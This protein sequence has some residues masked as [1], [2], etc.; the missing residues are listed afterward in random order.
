MRKDPD[1][2]LA[3]AL[4]PSL[5]VDLHLPEPV[6]EV[7]PEETV[8][9]LDAIAV[10]SDVDT[11]ASTMSITI[12]TSVAS[13]DADTDPEAVQPTVVVPLPE[14][15]E[16]PEHPAAAPSRASRRTKAEK[17][18][19]PG[20]KPAPEGSWPEFV[21]AASLH[22]VNLGDSARVRARKALDARIARSFDDRPRFVP[23]LSRKGG[24]GKT[25]VTVLLGMALAEVR[26]DR[27]LAIDANPDRGTLAD[28][29][30]RQTRSTV[31]DIVLHAPEL[32]G[33]D[34]LAGHVS[35]DATGLDVAASD[36]DPLLAEAFDDGGYN[37]VADVV[38]PHY[39]VVVTDSGTGVVHSVMRASLQ[40]A[41]AVVV[42]SGGSIDEARL[43]SETL[44]WLEA[45]NYGHLVAD[46]V[47]ALN[48]STQGTDLDKLHDIEDHFR[49][50]VRAVVRIPYDPELAAGSVV[51]Y[52]ALRPFT[53]DSARQLA[54]LVID[55]L[56]PAAGTD[57]VDDL[58]GAGE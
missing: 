47:V 39:G 4:P 12:P 33:F 18:L 19:R 11:A 44:T 41:D 13:V 51:R 45:N 55:G 46:A 6:H 28:R 2:D 34:D 53:R 50:R 38:A 25:T 1:D 10:T 42:V 5:T 36:T 21:Y 54:A 23:V 8:V 40:R 43:A 15:P 14:H 7:P 9:A 57:R 3:T 27:V 31:R 56:P 17:P 35:R 58:P 52:E 48:A 20:R 16:H 22:L 24:V 30:P 29:V 26:A 49:S 32:G 37:V